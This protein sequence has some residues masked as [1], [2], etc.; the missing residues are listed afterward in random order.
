MTPSQLHPTPRSLGQSNVRFNQAQMIPAQQATSL[1]LTKST[2]YYEQ[3]CVKYPDRASFH[4]YA[5]FIHALLLE[6]AP[7]VT[8]FVPQPYQLV[9]KGRLYTPD[10]YVVRSGR[11][12]V[13]EL[14]P[15]GKFDEQDEALLVAFFEQYGMHFEVVANETVLAQE[16]LARNWLPLIQVLAQ[17]QAQGIETQIEEQQLFDAARAHGD[18]L[19]VGEL[20]TDAPRRD[21]YWQ[22]LALYRLLHRHDLKCN[23]G[24][25]PLDYDKVITAWS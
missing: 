16:Q 14:K 2:D 17:A 12:Q 15:G 11:I 25:A 4:C 8:S 24:E 21:R 13:L 5:E 9:V 20:L 1:K 6:A 22:E 23:L 3:R 7:E 19:T 18:A 10:A